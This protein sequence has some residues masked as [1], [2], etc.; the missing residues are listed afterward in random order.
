MVWDL[1]EE[2]QWIINER[3]D[4]APLERRMAMLEHFRELFFP[5]E[6]EDRNREWRSTESGEVTQVLTFGHKYM[7]NNLRLAMIR[8]KLGLGPKIYSILKIY[9]VDFESKL[10]LILSCLPKDKI[11]IFPKLKELKGPFLHSP[12]K[13][14]GETICNQPYISREDH[15]ALFNHM[16]Y[17]MPDV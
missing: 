16:W 13:E 14:I 15:E 17:R 7:L 12:W 5:K 6:S 4:T 3:M 10:L 8:E 2:I 9:V 11:R 1:P